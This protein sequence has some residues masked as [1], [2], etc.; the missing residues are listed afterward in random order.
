VHL[1]GAEMSDADCMYYNKPK[2]IEES[3]AL[4]IAEKNQIQRNIPVSVIVTGEEKVL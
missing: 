1:P 4:Q 2:W 3:S